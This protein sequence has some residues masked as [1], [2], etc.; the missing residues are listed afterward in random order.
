MAIL[1]NPEDFV[2]GEN[3]TA[4]KLNNLVDGATFLG[5]A[6]QATDDSTLEVNDGVGGDGSL[7]VKDLGISTAKLAN[8]A[9]TSDKISSTDTEF[10]YVNGGIGIGTLNE[11]GYDLTAQKIRLSGPTTQLWIKDDDATD[12]PTEIAI[13]LNGRALRFGWQ[14]GSTSGQA[15]A[16][17]GRNLTVGGGQVTEMSSLTNLDGALQGQIAVVTDGDGGNP[18]LSM[19]TGTHGAGGSWK[20]LATP[21]STV[22]STVPGGLLLDE[23]DMASDSDTKGATQQSIKAYV[24]SQAGVLSVSNWTQGTITSGTEVQ[25]PDNDKNFAGVYVRSNQCNWNE[26]ASVNYYTDASTTAETFYVQGAG[27]GG[28]SVRTSSF[29]LVPLYT[30]SSGNKVM[31]LSWGNMAV[32]S[33]R[34]WI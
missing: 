34:Y 25:A 20:V 11:A 29:L 9:V 22:S 17:F 30:N 28:G 32:I 24:D 31:K 5:G 8:G 7:R 6:G 26:T 1:N 13:S 4:A 2:S 27:D 18:C 33:G 14:D 19:Y 12:T 21:G 10:N 23:D 16:I 15:F 3:I